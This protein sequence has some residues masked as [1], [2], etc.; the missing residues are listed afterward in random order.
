[1]HARV[2][3][4][5]FTFAWRSIASSIASG[6]MCGRSGSTNTMSESHIADIGVRRFSTSRS[7]RASRFFLKR[8]STLCIAFSVPGTPPVISEPSRHRGTT[9]CRLRSCFRRRPRTR[10][11]SGFHPRCRD[12]PAECCQS[13]FLQTE[14]FLSR[15]VERSQLDHPLRR[16][17]FHGL[18]PA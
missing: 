3:P 4:P 17:S 2:R 13:S 16:R 15:I 14:S 9:R 11:P 1:M 7:P 10:R 5:R 8:S 18:P 6:P 12:G